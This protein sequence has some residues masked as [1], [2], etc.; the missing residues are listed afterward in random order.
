M[1]L[2]R[3][4]YAGRH[5]MQYFPGLVLIV[6]GVSSLTSCCWSRRGRRPFGGLWLLLIGSWLIASQARL[7]GLTFHTSW[8]L[9]IIAVGVLIVAGAV[10]P[11]PERI[12]KKGE[13]AP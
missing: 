13:S 8:P 10:W 5:L 11:E 1:L 4:G 7:F 6:L 9:L 2:D 12:D 3:S